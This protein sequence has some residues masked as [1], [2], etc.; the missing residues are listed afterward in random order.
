MK[1]IDEMRIIYLSLHKVK[2][3]IDLI[4]ISVKQTSFIRNYFK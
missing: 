2:K 4:F 1:A 3:K